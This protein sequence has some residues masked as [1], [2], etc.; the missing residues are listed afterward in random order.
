MWQLLAPELRQAK[1]IDSENQKRWITQL[2]VGEIQLINALEFV[3]WGDRN[4]QFQVCQCGIVG[5]Q[6]EGWVSIRKTSALVIILPAFNQIQEA[7]R[8]FEEEYLPPAYL[9][10]KGAIFI[11]QCVYEE[12]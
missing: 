11:E 4:L 8:G 9:W 10:E 12:D 2:W 5:C 6:P 1:F 3:N 7:D